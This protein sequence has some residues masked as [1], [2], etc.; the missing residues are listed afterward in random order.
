LRFLLAEAGKRGLKQRIFGDSDSNDEVSAPRAT[1]SGRTGGIRSR[2]AE[3]ADPIPK[4]TA[5]IKAQKGPLYEYLKHEWSSGKLSTVQVQEIA[6]KTVQTVTSGATG[7][8]GM[9]AMGNWGHNAK[10]LARAMRNVLGWPEGVPTMDFIEL[11]TV[12]GDRTPH[13]VFLAA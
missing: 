2:V 12:K 6:L 4:T 5:E 7:V 1:S 11:P 8:D 3:S 9:A 13:P 10:N